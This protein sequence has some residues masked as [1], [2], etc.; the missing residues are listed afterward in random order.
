M[1]PESSEQR[2]ARLYDWE[3]D[4][5]AEDLPLYEALA[6]RYGGPVLELG[7]GTGRV[8][9]RLVQ[10][11]LSCTGLDAS[12]A[13]LERAA[14]R[15]GTSARLVQGRIE[16]PPIDGAYR[17]L[18]L[19]LD[20]LGLLVDGAVH[21][22]ALTALRQLVTHDGRLIIDVSNGNQ[23]GGNEPLEE[24]I[25]HLSRRGAPEGAWVTKW[26][27]R[28]A[29][30]GERIDDLLML[31]DEQDEDGHLRRTTVPLRLRWYTRYELELLLGKTGWAADEVYGDYDLAPFDGTSPRLI[32][33]ATPA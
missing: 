5:Y 13:M 19:A 24:L 16:D 32:V 28:R 18:V 3:H 9:E 4:D 15:L 27:V 17:T 21:T 20:V 14:A 23:R 25:H 30:L 8:L 29:D 33:V 2:A 22:A 11:G 1:S 7:C 26:V 12:A 10:T 31:Y 6:R